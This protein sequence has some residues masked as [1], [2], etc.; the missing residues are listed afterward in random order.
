MARIN[1]AQAATSGPVLIIGTGLIGTSIALGL[2]SIAVPVYLW[3]ASPTSLALAADMGAG[4]ALAGLNEGSVSADLPSLVVVA[5]PPDVVAPLVVQSLE[6]FRGAVVTEVASV[7]DAIAEEVRD[8]LGRRDD[9]VE[10][11]EMLRRYVGSHPMAGRENSGASNAHG[12]L[13][14]GRPWVVCP[15]KVSSPEAVAAVRDLAIDLGAVPAEL[16]SG[17]HDRAVALISHLPQLVSS[18]LAAQ[19]ASAPREF[20]SLAGSGLRDTTRI[21]SSDPRLWTAI[22]AGNAPQVREVLADLR[23]D[24]DQ[25]LAALPPTSSGLGSE[26]PPGMA[27]AISQV[28]TRGNEGARR[29]PGKHGDTARRWGYVEVL[30]PDQPGQLGRLFT[31]LG[32]IGVNMED[33]VLE[34]SASQPVGLARVMIDPADVEPAAAEL[35]ARGWRV[36]SHSSKGQR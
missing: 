34:H 10:G 14:V 13:F 30:V 17:E 8:L 16:E 26:I 6:R 22:I 23:A 31:E 5:A 3:D 24:L 25:L 18:L 32:A 15:T 33:L 11:T 19:L 29:I 28:M 35:A 1:R 9:D 27:G 7:K 2:R 4:M 21:A 20:L 36:A 12:D